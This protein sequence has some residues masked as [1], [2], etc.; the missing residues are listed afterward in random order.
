MDT[1][2]TGGAAGGRRSVK[3]CGKD[4]EDPV[5][6]EKQMNSAFARFCIDSPKKALCVIARS[7]PELS[8]FH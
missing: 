7:A 4:P 2:S 8:V 5:F 6:S 1:G 3:Y